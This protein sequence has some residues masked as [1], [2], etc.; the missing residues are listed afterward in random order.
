MHVE[1]AAPVYLGAGIELG[2]W[3]TFGSLAG[4][5]PLAHDDMAIEQAL[6][7]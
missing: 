6:Y 5:A 1:Y 2:L 4:E 3:L 7:R